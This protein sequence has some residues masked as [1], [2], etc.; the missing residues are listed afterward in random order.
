MKLD[1]SDPKGARGRPKKVFSEINTTGKFVI[2]TSENAEAALNPYADDWLKSM[3]IEYDSLIKSKTWELTDLAQGQLNIG[4]KWVYAR[5]RY[6]GIR[7]LK[8]RLVE[9]GCSQLYGV[10]Y[11]ESFSPVIRY[12]NSRIVIA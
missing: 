12:A 2:K 7:T 4:C 5:K 3:P 9:K 11:C 8:A 1:H 6:G 10:N